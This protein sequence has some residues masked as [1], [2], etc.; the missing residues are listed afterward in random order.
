MR[1][2]QILSIVKQFG[3][4]NHIVKWL[5]LRLGCDFG[6]RIEVSSFIN[7]EF[8]DSLKAFNCKVNLPTRVYFK[9]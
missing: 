8:T 5:A 2:A 3:F 4:E 7:T 1:S 9:R 6:W